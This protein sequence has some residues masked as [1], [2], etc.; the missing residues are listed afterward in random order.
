[1]QQ[2]GMVFIRYDTVPAHTH[3]DLYKGYVSKCFLDGLG[4]QREVLLMKVTRYSYDCHLASC[5]AFPRLVM[6]AT[7]RST[8]FHYM[9]MGGNMEF[10][11]SIY[12]RSLYPSPY[13]LINRQTFLFKCL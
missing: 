8:D 3:I 1:M 13:A 12:W 6:V 2:D 10:N 11:V 9:Q 7:P 4:F 5:A